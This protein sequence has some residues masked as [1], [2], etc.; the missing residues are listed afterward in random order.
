MVKGCILRKSEKKKKIKWLVYDDDLK[1]RWIYNNICVIDRNN[2]SKW[3]W[4]V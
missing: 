4:L 1:V 3:F 2:F